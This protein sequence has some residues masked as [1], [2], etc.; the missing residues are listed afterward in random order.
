M[1]CSLEMTSDWRL[2]ERFIHTS[3]TDHM[4]SWIIHH[5]SRCFSSQIQPVM[6][7]FSPW[8]VVAERAVKCRNASGGVPRSDTTQFQP[9][10]RKSVQSK[11]FSMLPMM[12][13]IF[14]LET[15]QL[16]ISHT[17]NWKLLSTKKIFTCLTQKDS[18]WKKNPSLQNLQKM[19]FAPRTSYGCFQK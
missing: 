1:T 3:G 14:L 19:S 8:G 16:M 18:F 5:D 11:F 9:R 15:C 13:G 6:F 17:T 10:H 12:K 7:R 2:V 4:A